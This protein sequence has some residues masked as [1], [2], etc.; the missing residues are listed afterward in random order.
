MAARVRGKIKN[1]L[2][3]R[4][5]SVMTDIA[6]RL[7]RGILGINI[8]YYS[9][10]N[11]KLRTVGIKKMRE[12][13]TGEAIKNLIRDNLAEYNCSLAQV[14]AFTTD[15]GANVLKSAKLVNAEVLNS[16]LDSDSDDVNNESL[17]AHY[18]KI[19]KMLRDRVRRENG[20]IILHYI[21]GIECAAHSASA[22]YS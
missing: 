21:T 4:M 18:T 8:Q 13:H 16:T 17:D 5:F 20:E 10:G 6:T 2:N 12:S 22:S 1:E 19:D 9:E 7:H 15:N 14:Y 3:G 11:I